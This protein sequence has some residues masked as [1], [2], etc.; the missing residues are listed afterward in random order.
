MKLEEIMSTLINKA[1]IDAELTRM[2]RD[3]IKWDKRVSLN[4]LDVVVREGVVVVAGYV[5]SAYRRDAALEL[6]TDLDGI[7]AVDN[8]IVVPGDYYRSDDEIE[9][10]IKRDLEE[11]LKISGEYIDVEVRNGIVKLEGEVFRPRLKAL[12]DGAAWELSGVRDVINMIEI[13]DPP[14][15]LSFFKTEDQ[16]P[17]RKKGVFDGFI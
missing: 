10:L 1:E 8:R 3:R 5:D 12:A 4:D 2:I 16:Q 13:S 15:H 7:W 14:R 11:E 17:E 9:R 6:I